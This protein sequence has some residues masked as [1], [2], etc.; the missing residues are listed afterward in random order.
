MS[1]APEQTH[2]VVSI[3]DDV[4]LIT[5]QIN[6]LKELAAQGQVS[7]GQ[8]YDFSIRWGT[9]LAGRLRRLTHYSSLGMLDDTDESRFADLCAEL[10]T[11]SDLI[12]R[13]RL[14]SPVFTDPVPATARRHRAPRRTTTR[15]ELARRK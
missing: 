12:T 5:E 7:E 8:R 13:F 4:E 2:R 14:A 11:L 9:I 15:L 10:R 3:D 1:V 6:G